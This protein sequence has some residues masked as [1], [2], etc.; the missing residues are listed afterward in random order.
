M[1]SCEHALLL[2]EAR[3][4][5]ET[6]DKFLQG[7]S[8]TECNPVKLRYSKVSVPV[9]KLIVLRTKEGHLEELF[10]TGA[11][12]VLEFQKLMFYPSSS[13]CLFIFLFSILLP[14]FQTIADSKYYRWRL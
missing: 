14:D 13:H 11:K 1:S 3:I 5:D 10:C 12:I 7:C 6:C 9:H 8:K 2:P 4:T